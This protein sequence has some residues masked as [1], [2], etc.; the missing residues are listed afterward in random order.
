MDAPVSNYVLLTNATPDKGYDLILKVAGLLPDVPFLVIASQSPL[1]EAVKAHERAGLSN[2]RVVPRTDDMD[3][4][5]RNAAAVA[6]PSYRFRESFSRVCIEAQR[7]GKPVIGSDKG[8]VPFLLAESGVVLPEDA[9]AWA[10][11]IAR[12][13]SDR[14]YYRERRDRALANSKR[15]SDSEQGEALDRLV[16]AAEARFLVAIGSGL[17]N[18]LH[19][20]P[21]IRN[22][23]RRA[24][25]RVDVVVAEDH[26]RSLFLVHDPRYVNAVFTLKQGVLRRAYDT[27]LVTHSFGVARVAFNADKVAWSR[28]WELFKPVGMHETVFNL[29]TARQL[30]GIPYDE[31]DARAYFC[32][33][34]AYAPP[35]E[36][37]VGLHAG[38]KTGQ[39]TVKRWPYYKELAERLMARGLR[40]ASFGTS[41]EYVEGTENR[42]GASIESMCRAMLDCS[43]FVSNDSGVMNIANALG[44]PLLALFAPT[45]VD[46][47]LPLGAATQ[48]IV[49]EKDCAPCEL[50]DPEGFTKGQCICMADI[51]VERVEER[52]LAEIG[53]AA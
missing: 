15:Y 17:G 7:H 53:K 24:G 33:G 8:N 1:D 35:G 51:G 5:Y 50:K 34:L 28:D 11:E 4:L 47:R 16:G 37:L 26:A 22:I 12:L 29:E 36:T 52:L 21:M 6:V 27:V 18:M 39:W 46:T 32:G 48:A 25:A 2:V 20:T 38:S 44:I 30:L 49:L 3:A 13:L 31:A 43:H 41:D 10:D 42:T 9:R 23:A 19:T 14:D 45:N 40:V